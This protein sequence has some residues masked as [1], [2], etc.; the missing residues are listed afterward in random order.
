VVI[1]AV[2]AGSCG[3][4]SN[5]SA[6]RIGESAIEQAL[7]TNL[8]TTFQSVSTAL[9]KVQRSSVLEGRPTE[10][11]FLFAALHFDRNWHKADIPSGIV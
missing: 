4:S 11:A 8:N 9:N 7:G 5:S 6:N 3:R 2:A 1:A 10:A